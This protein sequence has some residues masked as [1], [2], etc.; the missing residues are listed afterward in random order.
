MAAQSSSNRRVD[1]SARTVTLVDRGMA[2]GVNKRDVLLAAVKDEPTEVAALAARFN[3][4]VVV[5]GRATVKYGSAIEVGGQTM[6]QYVASMTARVIQTDSARIL[7]SKTFGP[8]TSSSMQR[9]G[10]EDKALAKLGQDAAPQI[11]SAVVEA[12]RQRQTVSR[13]VTLSIR[14][15]DYAGW[16]TFNM[17]ASRISGFQ[18]L[19]LREIVEGM[20]HVDVESQF[21]YQAVAD[22]LC[23]LIYTR[24]A[25]EEITP[26]RLKL[27]VIT[28]AAAMPPA[29]PIPNPAPPLA[30][31][32]PPNPVPAP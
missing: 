11:L 16:K 20:A 8:I 28:E 12:W 26:N 4:E 1:T 7:A 18:N 32:P 25:V 23:N 2:A 10:G 17:E 27:Y 14:G 24:L 19:R 22:R 21:D 31:V 30:P 15:M 6:H 3:A 13:T 9:T 29:A 5:T